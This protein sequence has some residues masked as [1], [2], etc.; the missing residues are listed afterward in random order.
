VFPR[1]EFYRERACIPTLIPPPLRLRL[2]YI[3]CAF[4]RG[5]YKLPRRHNLRKGEKCA[6]ARAGHSARSRR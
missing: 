5:E 4:S 1:F 6:P 3:L 2:R